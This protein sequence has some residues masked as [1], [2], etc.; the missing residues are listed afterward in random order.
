MSQGTLVAMEPRAGGHNLPTAA[1]HI[2][3]HRAVPLERLAVPARG[4]LS[5]IEGK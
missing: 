1:E 3:R 5:C 2:V 4:L